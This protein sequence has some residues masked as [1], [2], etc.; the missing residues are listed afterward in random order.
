MREHPCRSRD[1]WLQR[2]AAGSN[3]ASRVQQR[4]RETAYCVL[5]RPFLSPTHIDRICEESR[6]GPNS[7]AHSRLPPGLLYYLE[8]SVMFH[9]Y[10]HD[11]CNDLS[12]RFVSSNLITLV[13]SKLEFDL[14]GVDAIL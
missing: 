13:D 4:Y 10:V 3:P 1:L 11:C 8:F 6:S 7:L 5:G 14:V 12:S 2:S 9:D